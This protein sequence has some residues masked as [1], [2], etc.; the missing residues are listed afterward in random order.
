MAEKIIIGVSPSSKILGIQIGKNTIEDLSNKIKED[1][2][3]KIFPEIRIEKVDSEEIIVIKIEKSESKPVFAFGRAY[4][5]VGKT[6]QRIS[7]EEI[8]KMARETEKVY[9][10]KQIC[11]EAKLTDIDWKFVEEI[12]IP[13]YEETSGKKIAG[14]SKQVLVSL[15]CI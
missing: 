3:P 8:R 13:L 15:G 9:W 4:K 14:E 7:S 11:K 6:T 1:I 12:F 5:R 2:D 10:D